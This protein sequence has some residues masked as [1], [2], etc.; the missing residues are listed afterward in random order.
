KSLGD[1][2]TRE[3]APNPYRHLMPSSRKYWDSV[4]DITSAQSYKNIIAHRLAETYFIVAEALMRQDREAEALEY[5]NPIRARAGIPN[6]TALNEDILLEERAKELAFEGHRWYA[7][8]R[9]GLLV[10]RVRLY[11]GN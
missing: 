6:L 9:M 8:K 1:L 10:E 4:R 7:L 2:V 5:I 3:H 11:G